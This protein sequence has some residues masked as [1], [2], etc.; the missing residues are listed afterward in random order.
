M[1]GLF[2]AEM[3]LGRLGFFSLCFYRVNL[4]CDLVSEK[5]AS[6]PPESAVAS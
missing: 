6:L 5:S 1:F 3:R 4:H 2:L